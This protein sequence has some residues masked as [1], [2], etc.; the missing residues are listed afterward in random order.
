MKNLASDSTYSFYIHVHEQT[1]WRRVPLENFT[2]AQ[3]VK[4]FPAFYGT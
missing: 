1:T 4:K 2:M 3:L